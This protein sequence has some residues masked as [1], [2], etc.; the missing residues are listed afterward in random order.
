MAKIASN[1]SR[2][3]LFVGFAEEDFGATFKNAQGE[4]KIVGYLP[5]RLCPIEVKNTRNV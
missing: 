4:W 5:G 3:A 2:F 1:W